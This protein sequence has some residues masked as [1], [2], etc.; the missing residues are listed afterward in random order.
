MDMPHIA[1][2]LISQGTFDLLPFLAHMN[3]DVMNVHVQV[4]Y[5]DT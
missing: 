1:Y 3:N 4:V 2:P 5:V